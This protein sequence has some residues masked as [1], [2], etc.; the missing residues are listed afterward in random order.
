M[1]SP[2]M[3][4]GRLIPL[5]IPSS[6]DHNT[7]GDLF[8]NSKEVGGLLKDLSGGRHSIN[9]KIHLDP[10]LQNTDHQKYWRP[11]LGQTGAAQGHLSKNGIKPG[12]V[13]LFF[14]WF[15]EVERVA[16]EWRYRKDAPNQHVIFGWLEIER[17]YSINDERD[18][19]LRQF[20]WLQKQPHFASP[21]YYDSH[22]NTI[23]IGA[24]KSRYNYDSKSGGSYF[25]HFKKDLCLTKRGETR[26]VWTLPKW[27][28]PSE[29][30]PHLTYHPMGNR[31]VRE[32]KRVKLK[33][34]SKGQEFILDGSYYPELADWIK[35]I[36][37]QK[38]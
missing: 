3:P 12:D 13:F 35:G 29:K 7:F 10:W 32:G 25:T 22:L 16:S 20:P 21:D 9:S 2:I 1:P 5:P 30:K 19:C 37:S 36:I 33:S 34:A 18:E 24:N 23:Y 31:W 6:H 28:M 15:R 8:E 38:D 4:D 26:T 11:S 17:V 27:F 14:G